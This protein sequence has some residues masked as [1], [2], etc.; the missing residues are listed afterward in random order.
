[1]IFFQKTAKK[2]AYFSKILN[3]FLQ[4]FLKNHT[5]F[6][7]LFFYKYFAH[8]SEKN[9]ENLKFEKIFNFFPHFEK[10]VTN[11]SYTVNN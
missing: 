1:M 9:K 7:F 2:L 10:I 3:K 8:I 11:F 6:C 4:T 5:N